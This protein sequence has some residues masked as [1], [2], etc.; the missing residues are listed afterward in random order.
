MQ[1]KNLIAL[2]S[3]VA[4]ALVLTLLYFDIVAG[5]APSDE[6]GRASYFI[7][8]EMGE[9]FRRQNLDL[10]PSLVQRGVEEAMKGQPSSLSP[11]EM[12]TA[13]QDFQKLTSERFQQVAS[14]N[15]QDAEKF[16]AANKAQPEWKTTASGLQYK[17]LKAGKGK[18]PGPKSI[19]Q[20]HYTTTLTNG[21]VI[22]GSRSRGP[23]PAQFNLEQVIRG[24]KEFLP[25]MSEGGHWQ[26][27]LPPELAY[28]AGGAGPIPPNAVLLFD[29]ELVK[30]V[31]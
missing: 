25:M 14:A 11:E 12:Q 5:R 10:D 13:R 6:R 4:I 24:W 26:I 23:A 15:K 9:N 7:G 30:V 3:T 29:V 21:T 19:V 31:K 17:V 8:R 18:K 2:L 20:I 1:K 28:G 22:D 16:L 27:A